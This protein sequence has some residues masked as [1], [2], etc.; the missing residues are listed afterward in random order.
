M[1]RRYE[2]Q[3]AFADAFTDICFEAGL[4]TS[5]EAF[6]IENLC[7]VITKYEPESVIQQALWRAISHV[8]DGRGEDP[9]TCLRCGCNFRNEMH[10]RAAPAAHK[11]D[12][13][14]LADR[15]Q[16]EGS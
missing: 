6:L 2:I 4:P 5:R 3:E 12:M 11:R 15:L 7:E 14:A 1:D 13:L 8:H 16:A 10:R 9:D